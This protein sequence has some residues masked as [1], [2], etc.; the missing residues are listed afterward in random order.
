MIIDTEIVTFEL[1]FFLFQ[2]NYPSLI[3]SSVVTYVTVRFATF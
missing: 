1:H 2:K 3:L